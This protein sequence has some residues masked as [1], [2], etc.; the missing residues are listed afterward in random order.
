MQIHK[1]LNNYSVYVGATGL[2]AEEHGG[3][4]RLVNSQT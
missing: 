3:P 4:T 1:N 2:K